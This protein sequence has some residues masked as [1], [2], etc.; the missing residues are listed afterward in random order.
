ME[1]SA[2]HVVPDPL[3]EISAASLRVTPDRAIDASEDL[4]AQT[5]L[6]RRLRRM[7]LMIEK[8][9]KLV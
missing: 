9:R 1:S 4:Y 3:G 8:A 2:E 7:E 5:E 6:E